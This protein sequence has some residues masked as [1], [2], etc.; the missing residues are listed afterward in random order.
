MHFNDF[1]FLYEEKRG[2]PLVIF[3]IKMIITAI[4]SFIFWLYILGAIYREKDAKFNGTL[5]KN[6][7]LILHWRRVVAIKLVFP[8]K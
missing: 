2:I 4:L 7:I 1:L 5:E 3:I 6:E 8:V